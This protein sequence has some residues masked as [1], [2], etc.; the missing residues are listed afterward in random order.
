MPTTAF[1]DTSILDAQQYNSRS[2][3]LS[4]F[5]PACTKRKSHLID[6]QPALLLL[7][8]RHKEAWEEHGSRRH[9][10]IALC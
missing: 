9:N 4:T 5:V 1:L 7:R 8:D 3:A 2:P 10:G 6:S